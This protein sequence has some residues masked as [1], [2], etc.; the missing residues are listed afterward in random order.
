MDGTTSIQKYCFAG[1]CFAMGTDP[2][3][4]WGRMGHG[5]CCP[6]APQ[7]IGLPKRITFPS[8]SVMEPSRLP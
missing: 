8:G 6:A 5:C 3:L 7:R 2:R 4:I 1:P